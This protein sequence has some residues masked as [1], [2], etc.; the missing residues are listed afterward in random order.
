MFLSML[1]EVQLNNYLFRNFHSDRVFTEF[2]GTA[3]LNFRVAVPLG[4]TDMTRVAMTSE[5]S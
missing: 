4:Y 5:L 3:C 2:F 1:L